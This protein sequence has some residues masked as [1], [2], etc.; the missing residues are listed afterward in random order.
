VHQETGAKEHRRRPSPGSGGAFSPR[1][2]GS[3]KAAFD[4][5]H[6]VTGG[7]LL[8]LPV[9]ASSTRCDHLPLHLDDFSSDDVAATLKAVNDRGATAVRRETAKVSLPMPGQILARIG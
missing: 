7:P 6:D 9:G 8:S 3:S 5:L 2:A 4:L 1:Q